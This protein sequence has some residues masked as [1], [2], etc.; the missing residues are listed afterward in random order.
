MP[1]KLRSGKLVLNG[2]LFSGQRKCLH[3]G[4]HRWTTSSLPYCVNHACVGTF[5]QSACIRKA[6]R[7]NLVLGR[8]SWASRCSDCTHRMMCWWSVGGILVC[9]KTR[10]SPDVPYCCNHRCV[11]D[12]A[13]GPCP[14]PRVRGV[15]HH[16]GLCET[17]V[18]AREQRIAAKASRK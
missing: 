18:R 9:D 1:A 8:K 12:D 10:W 7:A 14:R 15:D 5:W 6:Q 16:D 13:D 4:C 2:R 11:I 17:H 3:R